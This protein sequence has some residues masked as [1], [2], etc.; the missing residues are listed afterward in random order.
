MIDTERYVQTIRYLE[1]LFDFLN[2]KLFKSELGSPVITVQLD[3]KNKRSGWFTQEKVWKEGEKEEGAYEINL[4]A[5]ELNRSIPEI[6]T[7]LLHEMCHYYAKL[8]ALK[9]LSQMGKYHTK[10]FRKICE[11]HGL[12]A[13]QDG[14]HGWAKTSLKPDM[15]P[16]FEEFTAKNPESLIYRMPV[17]KG[18][19]VRFNNNRKYLC[20]TCGQ[21]VR[22]T[23]EVHILCADCKL[24][25]EE[26]QF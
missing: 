8:H 25:M 4:S 14:T 23:K 19:A 24:P 13:E 5:Q 12:T 26:E 2:E 7:T 11:T 20:P 21:V 3:E 16:L 22:A 15:L 18:K 10:L 9:D 6:G 1:K 17:I